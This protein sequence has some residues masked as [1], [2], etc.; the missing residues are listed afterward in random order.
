MND[1]TWSLEPC[2]T[3]PRRRSSGAGLRVIALENIGAIVSGAP[4]PAIDPQLL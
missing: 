3:W 1:H 2:S 4:I